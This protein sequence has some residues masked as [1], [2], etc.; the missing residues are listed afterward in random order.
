MHYATMVNADLFDELVS[1]VGDFI[2]LDFHTGQMEAIR[3]I[4]KTQKDIDTQGM[5]DL[6]VLVKY[7]HIKSEYDGSVHK[8]VL[9]NA[10]HFHK[11]YKHGDEL[12]FKDEC[13]LVD[14]LTNAWLDFTVFLVE[15]DC[16]VSGVIV[17]K[18]AFF[19]WIVVGGR[20]S[21]RHTFS[22]VSQE[23]VDA[24][25]AKHP[26]IKDWISKKTDTRGVVG[27]V[28][29]L[30]TMPSYGVDNVVDEIAQSFLEDTASRTR[31][32]LP[33][34]DKAMVGGL[35]RRLI[36]MRVTHENKDRIIG[37][38][39]ESEFAL[40]FGDDRFETSLKMLVRYI[41]AYIDCRYECLDEYLALVPYSAYY[42]FVKL[43][44]GFKSFKDRR[45]SD[46][47][48]LQS[49]REQ[50]EYLLSLDPE[51]TLIIFDGH[52]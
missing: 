1:E 35:I 4:V 27:Q 13:S 30:L 15:D 6:E 38:L 41:D 14:E 24:L 48:R 17:Y 31:K 46:E 20:Y 21:N 26:D 49:M 19:D 42:Y 32:T 8:I 52:N 11:K 25:L 22:H 40:L 2:K 7:L 16:S 47:E 12:D 51:T 29:D 50:K 18:T 28:K 37:E 43:E 10:V 3:D 5:T 33:T 9:Y 23:R 36:E 39:S 45:Q 34:L 44:D